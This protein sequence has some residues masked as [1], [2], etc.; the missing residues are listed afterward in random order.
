MLFKKFEKNRKETAQ[1]QTSGNT[2]K[3]KKIDLPLFSTHFDLIDFCYHQIAEAFEQLNAQT[4]D[5][6]TLATESKDF[7]YVESQ[8]K[9]DNK[10]IGYIINL[11]WSGQHPSFRLSINSF[12]HGGQ[13]L[14]VNSYDVLKP[15]IDAYKNNKDL[16]YL[17]REIEKQRQLNAAKHKE[18][19][20]KK[21]AI[22]EKNREDEEYKL[23]Q[24][25]EITN[26]YQNGSYE[27]LGQHPYVVDKEIKYFSEM[28]L[29][30]GNRLCIPLRA[31]NE[32]HFKDHRQNKHPE[33]CEPMLVIKGY[34][35]IDANGNK[36]IYVAKK[37]DMKG[38]FSI[39]KG[40]ITDS[41]N[42][43][44][45]E[46]YASS[47]KAYLSASML[48][49]CAISAIN[50]N[51]LIT[52]TSEFKRLFNNYSN[53]KKLHIAA[54]NDQYKES[55][56]KGNTGIRS[57]IKAYSI[58]GGQAKLYIPPVEDEQTDWDDVYRD[59]KQ[60]AQ[61]AFKPTQLNQ[62][63]LSVMNLKAFPDIEHIKGYSSLNLALK[64]SIEK[65]IKLVPAI[66]SYNELISVLCDA[67]KH[68][69]YKES[70][71]A[72]LVDRYYRE[73]KNKANSV[74]NLTDEF[75]DHYIEVETID[76]ARD[77]INIINEATDQNVIFLK[78][79]MGS[80]K[81]QTILK[82]VFQEAEKLN[83]CPVIIS[84]NCSLV[85]A[86]AHDFNASHY[87]EDNHDY[88]VD[89]NSNKVVATGL[90]S[91]I[92]SFPSQRFEGFTI[93]TAVLMIDEATQVY[94]AITQGTIPTNSRFQTEQ[95]LV[96][97]FN[98][99]Q[100]T[101]LADADLNDVVAE[102]IKGSIKD[103]IITF[104]VVVK[105][106]QRDDINYNYLATTD[107]AYNHAR[108]L[109]NLV[110]NINKGERVFC[111]TDSLNQAKVI[112]RSVQSILSPD[113]ILIVS[114]ETTGDA[115]SQAFFE[116][117]DQFVIDNNIKL[118][119]TTPAVQSGIS[120]QKKHFS[121]CHTFFFGTVSPSD[122]M[123]MMHRVRYLKAFDISLPCPTP[124][125]DKYNE[126]D[127][128]IYM[129]NIKF[130]LDNNL[131]QLRHNQEVKD[132]KIVDGKI[133][134]N[135]NNERYECLAA[136]LKAIDTQQRNNATN[137]FLLQAEDKG[138]NLVN[139]MNTFN[140]DDPDSKREMKSGTRE[141]KKQIK[142]EAI[143]DIVGENTLSK[144]TYHVFCS[145]ER[146]LNQEERILKARYEVSELSGKNTVNEDDVIFHQKHG[147]EKV[148]NY[149][150]AE[151]IQSAVTN[152]YQE[153]SSNVARIDRKG[154]T[155]VASI[156]TI[157]FETLG[158]DKETL[159]GEF[160]H[161]DAAKLKERLLAD[162]SL[163]AFIRTKLKININDSYLAM[164][165][166][167]LLLERLLGLK[168]IVMRRS[169][170]ANRTQYYGLDAN[171]V[172]R[173]LSY[174]EVKRNKLKYTSLNL[175]V[176]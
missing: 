10:K 168:A 90:A 85:K 3:S 141:I 160:S 173:F 96:D 53:P 149:L 1:K 36:K 22:E 48:N 71:V 50:A 139:L 87:M 19:L 134:F 83:R 170:N 31:L 46:G 9:K 54:D 80:G 2:S 126:D 94:R 86:I 70:K 172:K 82:P 128:Y 158:L 67:V 44:L 52:V 88:S 69:G 74:R 166:A 137:F 107:A 42:I 117:P 138:I 115:R 109:N 20:A 5:V 106:K 78:A 8:S 136:K 93:R 15:Y 175:E 133:E 129:E 66:I 61:K 108:N 111:P 125:F 18:F 32:Q 110:E 7:R 121:I 73:Y 38:T 49:P 155:A 124:K 100:R 145:K 152:D 63:D 77:A 140:D 122:M 17:K 25:N 146:F 156:L 91:T 118:L 116:N 135:E 27:D 59:N 162:N 43:I 89:K 51:N 98:K 57:A 163:T 131:N 30:S 153:I 4:P 164:R 119:V 148:N 101:I 72:Q 157:C 14:V 142:Q 114:S 75:V 150:Y 33:R 112:E 68:T 103:S 39:V 23:K 28:K 176:A 143:N 47:E 65:L 154:H 64:E 62:L 127:N 159:Q 11:E 81:T 167:N 92:N 34:Q 29:I 58:A 40:S 60:K 147:R 35:T 104:A 174:V 105:P 97:T 171:Q 84:P 76:Q 21:E 45:S 12:K 102:H 41:K 132:L 6:S 169:S 113:E 37:G 56:G 123:Q 161:V 13:T 16:D 26:L 165:L 130:Y 79:E 55:I 95:K 151:D 24:F 120:L 99:A 144:E